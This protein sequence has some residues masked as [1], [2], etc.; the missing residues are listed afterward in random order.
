MSTSA[1]KRRYKK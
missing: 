1:N